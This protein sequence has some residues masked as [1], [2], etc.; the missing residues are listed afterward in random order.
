[1]SDENSMQAMILREA[2][3]GRLEAAELPRPAPGPGQLRVKVH[4][5]GVCRTD[6]HVVDG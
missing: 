6:L 4:A 2:A 3:A 1:M 5:C